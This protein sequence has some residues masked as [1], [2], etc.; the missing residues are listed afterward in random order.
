MNKKE[1]K[2]R[3]GNEKVFVVPYNRLEHIPDGFTPVKHDSRIWGQFDSMGSFVYRYDAEGEPYMQQII[4]YIVI[5]DESRTKIFT[6]MRTAGEPRLLKKLSIACGGHIDESDSGREVLFKAAVRELFEEV[7]VDIL[8]P[9]EIIGYIR[10]LT[11]ATCDHTGVV[12][13]AHATGDVIVKENDALVGKWMDLQDLIDNYENL[14]GWS[15]HLTDY[16]AENKKI[17]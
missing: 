10:D 12:I 9:F 5:L 2:Q 11:S 16:F 15:R 8:K 17:Y 4:P 3:Y 6:T 13:I 14:E 7:Q 1:L